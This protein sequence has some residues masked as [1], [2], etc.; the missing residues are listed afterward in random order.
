MSGGPLTAA[1][2]A[3]LSKAVTPAASQAV[4]AAGQRLGSAFTHIAQ[5]TF[6]HFHGRFP[7]P[8]HLFSQPGLSATASRVPTATRQLS[9]PSTRASLPP[10]LPLA[11]ASARSFATSSRAALPPRSSAP[12]PQRTFSSSYESHRHNMDRLVQSAKEHLE[13]EKS[14]KKA[15]EL[16]RTSVTNSS[17]TVARS[18]KAPLQKPISS[19]TSTRSSVRHASTRNTSAAAASSDADL[20]CNRCQRPF[21]SLGKLCKQWRKEGLTLDEVQK[22]LQQYCERIEQEQGAFTDD[23]L[24]SV[25]QELLVQTK[26]LIEHLQPLGQLEDVKL[27]NKEEATFII[28]MFIQNQGNHSLAGSRGNNT[29]E[30]LREFNHSFD[31]MDHFVDVAGLDT[32]LTEHV[33]Q[34]YPDVA[35]ELVDPN[36]GIIYG[37]PHVSK[38]VGYASSSIGQEEN[39]VKLTANTTVNCNHL[40]GVLPIVEFKETVETIAS[41]LPAGGVFFITGLAPEALSGSR[42]F[43]KGAQ[44]EGLIEYHKRGEQERYKTVIDPTTFKTYMESLGFEVRTQKVDISI[45]IQNKTVRSKETQIYAVKISDG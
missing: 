34:S 13:K 41:Q 29:L 1:A 18:T 30:S 23:K 35:V 38:Y 17:P 10:R 39:Q 9:M 36:V 44:K 32:H 22:E 42:Q 43:Q 24:C 19:Q 20:A 37:D 8:P 12:T 26:A 31:R 27:Y 16:L 15:Q 6:Q 14:L 25:Q 7:C 3:T 5:R 4:Q 2:A 33:L 11:N 21:E 28:E 40:V 45:R